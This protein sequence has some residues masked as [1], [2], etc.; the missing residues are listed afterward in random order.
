MNKP[1]KIALIILSIVAGAVFLFSAYAK[2]MP[3]EDFT[4]T[5]FGRVNVSWNVAAFAA[6]FFI[7][8]E[9]A[10]GLLLVCNIFGKGKWV[11]YSGIFLLLA[12]SAYLVGLWYMQGNDV[13]C[14]CM[15]TVMPMSPMWSLV[16][17]A[18]LL[19]ILFLLLAKTPTVNTKGKQILSL[20]AT[21][22]LVALPFIVFPPKLN[23]NALYAKDQPQQPVS[24]LRQGKHVV[25]FLSLTCSHCRTAAAVI[26]KIRE[27]HPDIPFYFVFSDRKTQRDELLQEFHEQT[28]T[29]DVPYHFADEKLFIELA[30]RAVP[31]IYMMDGQRI[32]TKFE[33]PDLK[34]EHIKSY[35]K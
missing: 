5:I 12:F 7:G 1:G 30:G 4:D 20:A 13:D 3:V 25:C 28:E 2:T 26:H 19:A 32:L 21:I 6:R 11:L 23:L 24:E 14:G 35:L 33:I 34:A 22:L 29:Q 17:N 16:K 18:A 31:S 15:G 8:I 9:A 27:Q 10:L